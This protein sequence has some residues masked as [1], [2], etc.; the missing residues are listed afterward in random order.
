MNYDMT[1]D[2]TKST[3]EEIAN[4][5]YRAYSMTVGQHH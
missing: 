1:V 5:I 4:Q 3:S 2:T